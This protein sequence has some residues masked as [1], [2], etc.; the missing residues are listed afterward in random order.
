MSRT[1]I[2]TLI[3]CLVALIL[4]SCSKAHRTDPGFAD[5]AAIRLAVD[6][7]TVFLYDDNTCQ[8]SWNTSKKEFT[9]AKDDMS[10][11]FTLGIHG[12]LVYTTPCSGTIE[13]KK[14]AFET[15]RSEGDKIWLQDSGSGIQAVIRILE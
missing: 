6:G 15:I 4:S 9:A 14:L 2:K 13:H 10:D 8:I 11:Y 7:N 1:V 3:F 5:D 12:T